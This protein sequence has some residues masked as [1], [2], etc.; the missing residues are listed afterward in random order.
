MRA[1]PGRLA[2]RLPRGGEV[3]GVDSS[4]VRLALAAATGT[5]VP[6]AGPVEGRRPGLALL[7]VESTNTIL[8]KSCGSGK[9][10]FLLPPAVELGPAV[11][12]PSAVASDRPRVPALLLLV[13]GSNLGLRA[14]ILSGT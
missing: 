7:G 1:G 5:F 14:G 2:C 9:G 13:G 3:R 12:W 10:I 4:D 11:A 6:T 8:D